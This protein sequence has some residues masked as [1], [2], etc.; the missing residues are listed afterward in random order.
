[1]K[2]FIWKG[3]Y[4]FMALGGIISYLGMKNEIFE[5]LVVAILFLLIGVIG[6]SIEIVRSIR[7]EW[8]STWKRSREE[9]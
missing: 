8:H 5:L 4:S 1:M 7:T 3:R 2:Q 9:R 6:Y